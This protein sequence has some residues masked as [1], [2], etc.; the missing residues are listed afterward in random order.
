MS[1]NKKDRDWIKVNSW[2]NKKNY[3]EDDK[4][5]SKKKTKVKGQKK[6]EDDL[7]DDCGRNQDYC[8]CQ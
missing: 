3:D 4:W 2:N 6:Y 8:V 1:K 5:R 7:C